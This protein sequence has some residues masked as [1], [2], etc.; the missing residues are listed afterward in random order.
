MTRSK[1]RQGQGSLHATSGPR[2]AR[3]SLTDRQARAFLDALA[4]PDASW[5]LRP[6]PQV[7]TIGNPDS[8][9]EQLVAMVDAGD[10]E[11]AWAAVGWVAQSIEQGRPIRPALLQ[12]IG[13]AFRSLYG[14]GAAD[15][16]HRRNGK[17]AGLVLGLCR[18][19]HRRPVSD[20]VGRDLRVVALVHQIHHADRKRWPLNPR[21]ANNAFAT[22]ASIFSRVSGANGVGDLKSDAVRKAWER[23]RRKY[24]D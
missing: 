6:K 10:T 9:A 24:A 17:R 16:A 8:A 15:S 18:P 7:G 20:L 21:S 23:M 13:R 3:A 11:S 4:K 22:A 19:N 12:W 2:S 14:D 5:Q 1:S